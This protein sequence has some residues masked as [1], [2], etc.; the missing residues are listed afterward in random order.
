MML[1]TSNSNNRIHVDSEC[2]DG[3]D[4]TGIHVPATPSCQLAVPA[5]YVVVERCDTCQKYPD[6]LTAA[7]IV[8]DDCR[9]IQCATGGHH[10]IGRRRP[11]G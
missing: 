5:G 1:A 10:A 7:A 9:W 2:C 4:G 8:C 11:L 6:D 3:C